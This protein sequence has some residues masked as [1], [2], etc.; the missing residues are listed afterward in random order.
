[1]LTHLKGLSLSGLQ[2]KINL[3]L[4][5]ANRDA[6]TLLNYSWIQNTKSMFLFFTF[7]FKYIIFLFYVTCE[8]CAGQLP[9]LLND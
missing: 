5:L 6:L 3:W 7:S 1:M 4:L 2:L 9:V 8:V